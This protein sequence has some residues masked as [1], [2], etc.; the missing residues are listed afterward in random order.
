MTKLGSL[1]P[2]PIRDVWPSE[3][4]D[5]TPWVASESGLMLLGDYTGMTLESAEAEVDIGQFRADII[6][7]KVNDDGSKTKVVIENQLGTSDHEH[8]GQLMVYVASA[9]AG[10]GVWIA[11]EFT[12]EH[13]KAIKDLNN[14]SGGQPKYFCVEVSA[15]RIGDSDP[16]PAF[17]VIEKPDDWHSTAGPTAP[18]K[19]Q[20]HLKRFWKLLDLRL[21]EAGKQQSIPGRRLDY[22]RFNIEGLP[23]CFSLARTAGGNRARLY[24]YRDGDSVF[25]RLERDQ[26]IISRELSTLGDTVY[27]N[28]PNEKR[29]SIDLRTK[30]HVY[31]ESKWGNEIDWMMQRLDLLRNVFMPRLESVEA[32]DD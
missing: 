9:A 32:S 12:P 31:D 18:R 16:A 6:C 28:Q 4:E 11:G 25:R 2:V 17:S 29:S 23:A 13:R 24:I 10:I 21:V 20:G 14:A 8:L 26:E 1:I 19:N 15:W 5:F 7:D 3:D 30:S 22:R 27:W